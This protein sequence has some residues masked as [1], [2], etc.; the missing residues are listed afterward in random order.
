MKRTLDIS[1]TGIKSGQV[2]TTARGSSS[3]STILLIVL[4]ASFFVLGALTIELY[5]LYI[6]TKEYGLL[7]YLLGMLAT[8]VFLWLSALLASR[9]RTKNASPTSP[10]VRAALISTVQGDPDPRVRSA[11]VEGL[12]ELDLEESIEHLEHKDIDTI[13]ISTLQRDPDPRVRSAAAEGLSEL[14]L[15]QSSYHHEHN[16]LEDILFEHGL[17]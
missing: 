8:A 11:A 10:K 13:L 12:A 4:G 15:E 16:K 5:R 14:E 3:V 6:A 7:A 17:S 1:G 9:F 2:D